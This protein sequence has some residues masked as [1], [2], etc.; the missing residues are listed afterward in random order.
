M[1]KIITLIILLNITSHTFS[2]KIFE[3]L[4]FSLETA[5][6]HEPYTHIFGAALK[7]QLRYNIIEFNKENS[8]SINYTPAIGGFFYGPY[9]TNPILLK[10]DLGANS[11]YYSTKKRGI[12]LGIGYQGI[13]QHHNDG[14]GNTF[15][16]QPIA[17][18][19]FT[20]YNE[21]KKRKFDTNITFNPLM[22][23]EQI[24]NKSLIQ[25]SISFNYYIKSKRRYKNK[26]LEIENL[27]TE[28]VKTNEPNIGNYGAP[29]RNYDMSV[30]YMKTYS[31]GTMYS[32]SSKANINIDNYKKWKAKYGH[33]YT[34]Y[35]MMPTTNTNEIYYL[36][37]I[38]NKE[39]VYQKKIVDSKINTRYAEDIRKSKEKKE[40]IK[41]LRDKKLASIR[42]IFKE[43]CDKEIKNAKNNTP[44]YIIKFNTNE[45]YRAQENPSGLYI[46]E[47]KNGKKNGYGIF[48]YE[49]TYYTAKQCNIY[50]GNWEN[51]KREGYGIYKYFSYYDDYYEYHGSFKN[52]K[53][54]GLGS[55]FKNGRLIIINGIYENG[56][57]I[58]TPKEKN[59][60]TDCNIKFVISNDNYEKCGKKV[61]VYHI[62]INPS[63]SGDYKCRVYY[64]SCSTKGW[65]EI[66]AFDERLGW[67][68][69]DAIESLKIKYCN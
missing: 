28:H 64:K 16:H 56:F 34:I 4:G 10:Y 62:E 29:K 32:G 14:Y 33:N 39:L 51:D 47:F 12:A 36:T 17:L 40:K 19:S 50:K 58:S 57:Q 23:T 52:G 35:T 1:K 13:F 9:I 3:S 45:L 31:I 53:K 46:G 42:K 67:S 60:V 30:Y 26:I 8:L 48:I 22:F 68:K 63:Y 24:T 38:P 54:H 61:T 55:V 44:E 59:N 37:F 20:K 69:E 7:Y 18:V 43:T 49:D 2:Q 41:K 65:Y 6:C 21:K 5:Y 25:I 15:S 66:G 11:T 27:I